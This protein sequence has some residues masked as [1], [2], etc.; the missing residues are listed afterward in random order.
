MELYTQL[1][2]S[3]KSTVGLDHRDT[4]HSLFEISR[5]EFL[6]GRSEAAF[7]SAQNLLEATTRVMG[8]AHPDALDCME[9]L[10]W[11]LY[12]LG[13]RR[14]A[15]DLVGR[16]AALSAEVLG[17]SHHGSVR[18]DNLVKRWEAREACEENSSSGAP[19]RSGVVALE[20]EHDAKTSDWAGVQD[21]TAAGLES[22]K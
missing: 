11:V 13:R 21:G 5:L 15:I 20:E 4:L 12:S 22:T 14:S 19:S 6:Q 8:I 18:R 16:C 7:S 1:A 3:Q 10:A 17:P 9:H 2:E